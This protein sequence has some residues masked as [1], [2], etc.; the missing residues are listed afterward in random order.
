MSARLLGELLAQQW[1]NGV[2]PFDRE[3]V[4]VG[5][6]WQGHTVFELPFRSVNGVGSVYVYRY[7]P[8]NSEASY[9]AFV[10]E[11]AFLISKENP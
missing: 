7:T 10:P 1:L 6:S 11:N 4:D 8:I 3:L 9:L 2:N 5:C